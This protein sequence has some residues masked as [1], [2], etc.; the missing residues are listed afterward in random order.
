MSTTVAE[1]RLTVA[2]FLKKYG[3][4]SGV[5]LVRG[6][7]VWAGREPRPTGGEFRMPEFKH[8]VVCLRAARAVSAFVDTNKLGWVAIND[9][10]VT[11]DEESDT[12]RGADV[13]YISY[14]RL[15]KGPVPDELK[16]PP[17]LVVEV[18]SPTDRWSQLFGKVGEYLN[19][20]VGVVVV[21]DPN[22]ETVS[23]YR[24]DGRQQILTSA[25]PLTIPDVLPGFTVPVAQ[26][27]E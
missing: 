21:I 25:D 5:E 22:T 8:G 4:C 10:F 11:V 7:V 15:P 19:A 3:H 24:D 1:E 17:E 23:V 26:F 13:L 9:T 18:R 6:R 14:A 16:S 27:F 20:G 12:V 2:E